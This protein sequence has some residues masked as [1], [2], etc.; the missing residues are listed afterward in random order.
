MRLF[1]YAACRWC[2][3]GKACVCLWDVRVC[4]RA[5]VRACA[6]V[7]GAVIGFIKENCKYAVILRRTQ[8]MK[9][10]VLVL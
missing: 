1:E 2:M 3:P 6:R 5:C 10:E 4:V 9:E 8:V 7:R